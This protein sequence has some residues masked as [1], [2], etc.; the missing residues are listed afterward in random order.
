VVSEESTQKILKELRQ[1]GF[2]RTRGTGSHSWWEHPSGA[3]V[4]VPDGHRRISPG[5]VRKV[6]KAIE[7]AR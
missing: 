6:R 4:A 1:A 7:E 2:V 3:G 5:V